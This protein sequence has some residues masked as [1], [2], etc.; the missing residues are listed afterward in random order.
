MSTFFKALLLL[1]FAVAQF[2]AGAQKSYNTQIREA[3]SAFI[4]TLSPLQ[5]KS[6]LLSFDDTAGF[7]GI[8][9]RL[10][11]GQEPASALAI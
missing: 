8:T 2:T 10:A 11:Y 9:F 7:S 5:K 6:A 1:C 3:S 4:Q